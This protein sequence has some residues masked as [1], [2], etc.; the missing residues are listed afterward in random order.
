M[1]TPKF[2]SP[3]DFLPFEAFP[4]KQRALLIAKLAEQFTTE[5]ANQLYDDGSLEED[6]PLL[7]APTPENGPAG[8]KVE[9]VRS[10]RADW[11][12]FSCA[13]SCC[14][15]LIQ[16]AVCIIRSPAEPSGSV[17][18]LARRDGF[19][20]QHERLRI[21]YR[22]RTGEGRIVIYAI[23]ERGINPLTKVWRYFDQNK[24]LNLICSKELYLRRLDLLTHQSEGDPYEGT[25]TFHML[26]VY[27][28]FY[29]QYVKP[30]DDA[31]L[32]KRFEQERRATFVSCW[33]R[34]ESE[35]WLALVAPAPFSMLQMSCRGSRRSR[36]YG[37]NAELASRKA[38]TRRFVP[39]G[40]RSGA[41]A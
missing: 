8:L 23:G 1:N 32:I 40:P 17:V 29:R 20:L 6:G 22:R 9:L 3:N 7:P 31:E 10:A 14:D 11:E 26:E 41:S 5:A 37:Q 24:A 13:P 18:P 2:E 33:Q 36:F 28:R 27:K 4:Q 12:Y 34:S 16:S 19:L 38:S 15:A 21:V 30:A 39:C 25:P 35:S